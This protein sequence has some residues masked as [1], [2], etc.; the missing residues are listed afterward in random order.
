MHCYVLLSDEQR[1]PPGISFDT[2]IDWLVLDKRITY[3]F[4]DLHLFTKRFKVK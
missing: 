4:D 1:L 3:A 2:Y